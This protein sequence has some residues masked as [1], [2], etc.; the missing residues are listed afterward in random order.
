MSS[1]PIKIGIIGGSGFYELPELQK[2]KVV[3]NIRTEFGPPS[4][5]IV[6]GEIHGVKCAVLA[7]YLLLNG[8]ILDVM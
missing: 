1:I 3:E 2:T 4:A 8:L 5:D 6:Q 7:R